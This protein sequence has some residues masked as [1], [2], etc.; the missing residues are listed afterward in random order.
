[1]AE[2]PKAPLPVRGPMDA[3]VELMDAWMR[4]HGDDPA[5]WTEQARYDYAAA[6]AQLRANSLKGGTR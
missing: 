4:D 5:D 2:Y 6:V 3:E 1:M